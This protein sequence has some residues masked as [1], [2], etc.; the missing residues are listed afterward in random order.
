MPS[1][2]NKNG[3]NSPGARSQLLCS[4]FVQPGHLAH[5][6][7]NTMKYLALLLIALGAM[8]PVVSAQQIGV[9]KAAG[10]KVVKPDEAETENGVRLL[11]KRKKNKGKG[12]KSKGKGKV[13]SRLMLLDLLVIEN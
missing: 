10:T 3:L 12:M 9:A 13:S 7:E 6:K 11:P 8:V 4:Q 1:P 2:V 5:S